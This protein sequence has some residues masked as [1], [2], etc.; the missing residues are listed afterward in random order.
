MHWN[1]QRACQLK[2]TTTWLSGTVEYIGL[3]VYEY[4]GVQEYLNILLYVY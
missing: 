2:I 1:D 4:V 3:R